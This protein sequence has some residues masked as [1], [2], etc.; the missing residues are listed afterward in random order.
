MGDEGVY[1][2]SKFPTLG[3]YLFDGVIFRLLTEFNR[4][5]LVENIDF[6]Q[7]I[8]GIYKDRKYY[9]FYSNADNDVAYPDTLRVYDAR[10]GRWMNRPVNSSLGDNFGYPV[11]LNH[12]NNELYVGS[13]RQDA[14]YELETDDDSDEGYDTQATYTTKDFSSRDFSVASGGGFGIDDV[15]LKLINAVVTYYGTTGSAGLAWT[16]DRGLHS[17]S[18]TINLSGTGDLINTTFIV[19][20]SSLSGTP[21]DKT[22]SFPFPNDAVG[23]R[24]NFSITNNGSSTRP[25]IKKIKINALAIDEI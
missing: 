23:R 19:N 5:V 25:K 8:F 11:I 22:K 21:P 24:F 13:S 16:A 18:K 20:T 1:F 10:F 12:T 17:G 2:V 9:L 3:V 6:S 15:K 7:R 4:D 14:I